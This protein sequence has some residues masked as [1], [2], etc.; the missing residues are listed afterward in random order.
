MPTD[1]IDIHFAV[2]NRSEIDRKLRE[3]IATEKSDEVTMS[4]FLK[5]IIIEYF[6]DKRKDSKEI[7]EAEKVRREFDARFR[8]LEEKIKS[9]RVVESPNSS[10]SS[11]QNEVKEKV[12]ALIDT[13]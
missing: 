12:K 9:G 6:E 1:R 7:S 11:R 10:N 4:E 2:G 13:F 5:E 3:I 8:Q